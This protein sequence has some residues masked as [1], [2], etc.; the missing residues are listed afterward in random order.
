[1]A[2]EDGNQTPPEKTADQLAM[3]AVAQRTVNLEVQNKQLAE[4]LNQ[5]IL[6]QQAQARNSQSQ[7][8]TGAISDDELEDLA[9][10]NPKAYAR[11]IQSRATKSATAMVDSR[12]AHQNDVNVVLSQLT[13]EYPELGDSTSE[14]TKK[15]VE[16]YQKMPSNQQTNPLAYKIAVRDAAA[17]LGI[18]TKT[19][20]PKNESDGFAVSG[21][22]SGAQRE[23]KKSDK[24]DNRSLAFA[25][26]LGM[27]IKDE[28]VVN[29]IKNRSK[30]SYG[31]WE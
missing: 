14:L 9:Y 8:A 1:M 21:N 29:A 6:N 5:L 31:G 2:V 18:L 3:E 12:L 16:M 7:S 30:R 10:K 27:N 13:A 20:R 28:K 24:V 19:K 15:A 23:S 17:D 11:E 4:Q 26:L 22:S 25:E